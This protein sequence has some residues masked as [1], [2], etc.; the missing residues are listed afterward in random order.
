MSQAPQVVYA[1]LQEQLSAIHLSMQRQI[2]RDDAIT[3]V[4]TEYQSTQMNIRGLACL[5]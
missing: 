2:V 3:H 4:Y 5:I 1:T